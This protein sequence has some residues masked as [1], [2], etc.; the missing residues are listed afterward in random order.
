MNAA[1][2][3]TRDA[4]RRTPLISAEERCDFFGRL[5]WL[6][7]RSS[8]RR[9]WDSLLSPDVRPRGRAF[10]TS[11]LGA[12]PSVPAP[13]NRVSKH[14]RH[15]VVIIQENRSFENFFAGYPGANAPMYGYVKHGKHRVKV[16]LQ[17]TTFETNP[18][19]PHTWKAGIVGWDNGKMDGFHA[20]RRSWC[21]EYEILYVKRSQVA[22]YWQMAKPIRSRRRNVSDRVRRQFY[23]APY[24]RCRNGQYEPHEGPSQLSD[25]HPNDCDSPPGTRSSFVK[26]ESRSGTRQRPIPVLHA[27]QHDG[28]SLDTGGT[29]GSTMSTKLL[30]AG[31]WSPFEAIKYVRNGTDWHEDIIAP[32]TK[33]LTDPE[34]KARTGQLGLAEPLRFRSPRGAQ[35]SW[36]VLGFLNRERDR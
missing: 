28:R 21:R 4:R 14:I 13:G 15:V 20:V 17:Q 3:A 30:N 31:I 12:L 8:S 23:R 6:I 2:R 18:N 36:A 33:I 22:P 19:L 26:S 1:L 35:R 27:V 9:C 29:R 25:A 5:A 16:R 7:S 11:A 32:Q 10:R 24:G 34:S